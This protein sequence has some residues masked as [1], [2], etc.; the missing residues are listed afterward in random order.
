MTAVLA[1]VL[2]VL[3]V[4]ELVLYRGAEVNYQYSVDHAATGSLQINLD[5][6][7]AMGCEGITVDMMDAAHV[8]T[9][10]RPFIRMTPTTFSIESTPPRSEQ[11]VFYLRSLIKNA[12]KEQSKPKFVSTDT[13]VTGCRLSGSFQTNKVHGTLHILGAGHG[14]HHH[15]GHLPHSGAFVYKPY[16]ARSLPSAQL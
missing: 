2:L 3:V 9:N 15:G 4:S 10:V 11:D 13:P 8:T 12:K 7:I 6:S 14:G 5:I 16:R 1:V